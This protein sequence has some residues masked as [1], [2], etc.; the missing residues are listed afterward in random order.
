M[1]WSELGQFFD[2]FHG[3]WTDDSGDIKKI[4]VMVSQK[5]EGIPSYFYF[6]Q[7]LGE[8]VLLEQEISGEIV[9]W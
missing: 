2:D 3:W 6:S 7:D 1:S 5:Y 4:V 9:P 8:N